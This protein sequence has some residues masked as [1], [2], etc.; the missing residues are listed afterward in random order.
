L[1]YGK[2]KINGRDFTSGISE[3]CRARFPNYGVLTL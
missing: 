2:F 3:C 1:I